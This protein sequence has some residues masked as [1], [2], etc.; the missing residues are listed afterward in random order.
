MQVDSLHRIDPAY[1]H[2]DYIEAMSNPKSV[3][4]L[5]SEK[6]DDSRSPS[7]N[8]TG[9]SPTL[10][11]DVLQDDDEYVQIT[12]RSPPKKRKPKASPNN[13]ALKQEELTLAPQTW[14]M[15]KPKNP[16][17]TDKYKDDWIDSIV[18]KKAMKAY[19]QKTGQ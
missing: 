5:R 9:K 1:I 2:N 4:V 16:P 19:A 18:Y 15:T 8:Q 14:S 13:N 3:E 11:K 12:T 7:K 10:T 17:D 6:S